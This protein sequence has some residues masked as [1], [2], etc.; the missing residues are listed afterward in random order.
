MWV[1]TSFCL[2]AIPVPFTYNT[3]R[4]VSLSFVNQSPN[5]NL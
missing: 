5:L 1:I 2:L 3:M 4:I